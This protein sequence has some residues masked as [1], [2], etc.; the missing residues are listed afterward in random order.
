MTESIF[1]EAQ[2]PNLNFVDDP[3]HNAH[4]YNVRKSAN[5]VVHV[6]DAL[7]SVWEDKEK[8]DSLVNL[9]DERIDGKINMTGLIR[10]SGRIR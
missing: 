7:Q 10:S 1:F 9:D 5:I 3:D 8:R 4:L 2:V 6:M